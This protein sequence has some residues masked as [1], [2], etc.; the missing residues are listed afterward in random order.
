MNFRAVFAMLAC[1]CCHSSSPIR[2]EA[3]IWARR[4]SNSSWNSCKVL[5]FL[6]MLSSSLLQSP[7]R[8]DKLHE[9]SGLHAPD[10]RSCCRQYLV[11]SKEFLHVLGFDRDILLKCFGATLADAEWKNAKRCVPLARPAMTHPKTAS[12]IKSTLLIQHFMS[13]KPGSK[14]SCPNPMHSTVV[15]KNNGRSCWGLDEV[16]SADAIGKARHENV[17]NRINACTLKRQSDCTSFW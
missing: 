4:L 14:G 17:Q 11:T 1:R 10:F 13:T 6:A 8:S 16:G 7:P 12:T 2:F 5:G 15:L 9:R 3:S